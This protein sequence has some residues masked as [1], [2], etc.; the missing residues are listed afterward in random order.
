MQ[1]P[2][3]MSRKELF[4]TREKIETALNTLTTLK[5]RV[6]ELRSQCEELKK[7]LLENRVEE[8]PCNRCGKAIQPG[9]EVIVRDSEGK[10]RSRYHEKCFKAL[11]T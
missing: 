6:S 11:L 9:H 7:Q 8:L 3:P 2:E 5:N 1:I 10:E 4:K